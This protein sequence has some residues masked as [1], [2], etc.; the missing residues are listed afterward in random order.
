M[1]SQDAADVALTSYRLDRIAFDRIAE[2]DAKFKNA[3]AW[4]SWMVIL[5]NEREF[6]VNRINSRGGQIA[7][8]H[9]ARCNGRRTD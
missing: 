4:C 1:T 3:G 8:Q 2:I 9:Q 7:H 6:L 5:A